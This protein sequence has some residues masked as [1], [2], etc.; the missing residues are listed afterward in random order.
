MNATLTIN[1]DSDVLAS[2]DQ[3]AKA[4]RTTL[5]EVVAHQVRVMAQNWQKS[6]AGET[7]LTDSLRGAIKLPA[8]YDEKAAVTEALR[9]KNGFRE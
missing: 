1:L 6:R 4:R 7:P 3:E 2:A 5:S 8:D 9:G